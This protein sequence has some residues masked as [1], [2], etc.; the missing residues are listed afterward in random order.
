VPSAPSTG[1][2]ASLTV[3]SQLDGA[4]A[5]AVLAL[6]DAAAREDRVGPLSEQARL[7]ARHGGQPARHLLL[8]QGGELAG[9]A[10]LDLAGAADPAD[11]PSGELVIHPRFRRRGLG[12]RLARRLQAEAGRL[13]AGAG[14]RPLRVWAHGDLPA[15]RALAARA[16]FTRSRALW[17]M[18]RPLAGPLPG[19]QFPPGVTVRT[20]AVGTDEPAWLAL[21]RKAFAHHPEQ[22]AWTMDDLT[23]REREPWFDPAGFFLAERSGALAGFHWTKVHGTGPGT[24]GEPSGAEPVGEVYVVGVD[25][26]EQG[27]GLGR[28][29]TLA[30][31]QHLRARGLREVMLY[32]DEDN[33]AAI[34]LYESLGFHHAATDVM[35][36]HPG[37]AGS[38]A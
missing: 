8:T 30:G 7:Q 14:P 9:Y 15:A 22:G 12:L 11:G 20:F 16:G 24:P 33:T 25:P 29:L 21:N 36:R 31:L 10:Q 4:A 37:L 19:P 28:A 38:A 6:A 34:R 32:V 26:A 3:T 17:T 5:A 18:R 35:F 2:G 1:D 23:V 13:A 27:S